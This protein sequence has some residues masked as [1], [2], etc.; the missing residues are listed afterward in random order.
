MKTVLFACIQNAGRSQIAEAWFNR[1]VDAA[2]ARAIS[3]GTQ[4]APCVHP[5][6]VKAMREVG[7]DLSSARPRALTPEVARAADVFIAMGCGDAIPDR[8]GVE[9]DAWTPDDPADKP[10]DA[11]RAIR[12]D[13][14]ERVRRLLSARRWLREAA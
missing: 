14:E 3:A 10:L 2:K 13:I 8:P 1:L 4:P 9:I 6:V 12:D 5:T 11:V 7:I